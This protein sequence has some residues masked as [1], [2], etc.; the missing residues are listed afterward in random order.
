MRKTF[1]RL[2]A[3]RLRN[4]SEELMELQEE[5]SKAVEA[6]EEVMPKAPRKF[7]A[8]TWAEAFAPIS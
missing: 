4:S 3:A 1:L 2:S 8:K 7:T 5:R 6:Q